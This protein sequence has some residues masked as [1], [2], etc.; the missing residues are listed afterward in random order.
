MA[1]RRRLPP[2]ELAAMSSSQGMRSLCF[3]VC[4]QS[5]LLGAAALSPLS[6]LAHSQSPAHKPAN[7]SELTQKHSPKARAKKASVLVKKEAPTPPPPPLWPIDASPLPAQ[8]RWDSHGLQITAE[9]S[10]LIQILHDFAVATGSNIQ[11]V[12]KD[13]R[14]YGTYGPGTARDVLTQLLAGSGYNVLMFG[15]LGEGAP[16]QI[17]LSTRSTGSGQQQAFTRPAPEQNDDDSVDNDLEGQPAPPQIMQPQGP[18]PNMPPASQQIRS[19]QQIMEEMQRREQNLQQQQ[20][21]YPQ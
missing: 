1:D 7:K 10:S 3:S 8:V 2:G 17:F 21:Q 19:P 4:I 12:G 5:L 18:Q 14:I 6:V 16:R 9:N 15:D 20:Q 11:G 13:V